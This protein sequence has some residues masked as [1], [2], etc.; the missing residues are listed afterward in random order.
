MPNPSR[1]SS[2]LQNLLIVVHGL[3]IVLALGHNYLTIPAIL[4]FLGRTHPLI[5]HFPIV[6]LLLLALLLWNPNLSLLSDRRFSENLFLLTLLLTGFTVIAGLLLAA[7]DGYIQEEFK[8]HK[9]T[10]I[11]LFWLASI[12]YICWKKEKYLLSQVMSALS[13]ICII[14]TGHLGASLTHGE[15]FLFGPLLK[16]NKTVQVEFEEAQSFDHVIKPILEQKCVS[17]HKASKQK[18]DLRL[19]DLHYVLAGGKHGP[20]IDTF[21]K[22]ESILLQRIFLPLDDEE[23]MPP[24]GKNQL[25]DV[26]VKLIESW[27]EESETLD[28]KLVNFQEE[29]TFFQLAKGLFS[30]EKEKEYNFNFASTATIK[31]LNDD[32]RIVQAIYPNTPALRVS[33]FGKAQ[34]DH[35]KLKDLDKIRMQMVELNLSNMPLSEEDIKKMVDFENLEKINLNF[36]GINGAYLS[37]LTSLN[38]LK[39]LSL[40]GNPIEEDYI[41]EIGQLIQ[42]EHLYLWETGLSQEKIIELQSL[43]PTTK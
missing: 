5:L 10:G 29:G 9:W 15:D 23:H 31:R 39:S 3:I 40:T 30:E 26:E 37:R 4:E 2:I 14:I 24:K 12:W 13:A 25:T 8:I 34:Y 43:L 38:H 19:D 32:Y 27:I 20:A 17:C 7:E 18:G 41:S 28:K 22:E 42:L 6:L 36:T 35:K 16:N 11:G 33:F 1:V 21:Q